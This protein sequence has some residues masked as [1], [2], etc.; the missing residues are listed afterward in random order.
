MYD[1][2]GNILDNNEL[3]LT[4]CLTWMN[5]NVLYDYTYI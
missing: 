3:N 4:D 1:K 2:N 5:D